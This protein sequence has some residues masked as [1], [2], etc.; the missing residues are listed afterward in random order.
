MSL[1]QL[2][3]S[4]GHCNTAN[5]QVSSLERR[6]KQAEV[7]DLKPEFV[8]WAGKVRDINNAA[9]QALWGVVAAH[10]AANDPGQQMASP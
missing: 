3:N 9:L 2:C 8:Q 6:I 4:I 7:G 5:Q 1:I 10:P